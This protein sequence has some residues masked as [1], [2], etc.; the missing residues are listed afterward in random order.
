MHG[1]V[2]R[3]GSQIQFVPD[4][5]DQNFDNFFTDFTGKIANL[6]LSKK[7]TNE[8]Y[9]LCENLIEASM[10]LCG[11]FFEK[12]QKKNTEVVEI[13]NKS[14]NYVLDRIHSM[15]KS[16]M[17]E[18]QVLKSPF[19]VAPVEKAMGLQWKFKMSENSDLPNH[20]L[21]QTTFQFVPISQTI[22]SLFSHPEF[23]SKFFEY[24]NNRHE[25]VEGVFKDYCCGNLCKNNEIFQRK[26][27][28]LIQLSA[29]E[30]NTCCGLKTKANVH[31]VLGVYF[32][33][34]NMPIKHASKLNNIYL[35][36]LCPSI[37]FKEFGCSDDN[38]LEEVYRDL[39]MLEDNGVSIDENL[40]LNVALLSA[41]VDNLEAN[42]MLGFSEGFSAKFFCRFCE[43]TKEET[44]TLTVE[45]I[46]KR[47]SIE[48][49][50]LQL[51]NLESDPTLS[52][53]QTK[54]VHKNCVLNGL[55]NFHVLSNLTIDIMHDISEGV[56][57]YF[58]S[59]FYQ[60]CIDNRICNKPDLIHRIRDYNYGSLNKR[61]KPSQ[62]QIDRPNLG[63]NATQSYTIMMHLP[64]IFGDKR[65]QLHD[66]WPIMT[67]LLICMRIIYSFEISEREIEL[68]EKSASDHLAGMVNVF[69]ITLKPKHHHMLHH[70]NAIRQMGPPR[71]MWMMKYDSKHKFFTQQARKTNNFINITKSLAES[72]QPYICRQKF[73][74]DDEFE[75]SKKCSALSECNDY[76]IYRECLEQMQEI[77]TELV[78]AMHFLIV[79][80]KRFNKGLM[81]VHENNVHEIIFVLKSDSN[82]F[83]ICQ[84]YSVIKFEHLLNSFQIEKSNVNSENVLALNIRCLNMMDSFERKIFKNSFFL[85]AENTEVFNSLYTNQ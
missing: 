39:K 13:L 85:I 77:D 12:H 75:F 52:L 17:R 48:E 14:Q 5:I 61:N 72:H 1:T 11:N 23:K 63:Q 50:E 60:F 29:D 35:V 4:T 46:S 18:K 59:A 8:V 84:A 21:V 25:C 81:I 73:H 57:L 38:V 7:N 69:E 55:K 66:V 32:Q 20:Q 33:I 79:N 65:E 56:I 41:A 3:T 40:H 42:R 16:H 80:G 78:V 43:C 6:Q 51:E 26:D 19:Y 27:T 70:S 9:D 47:R 28:I 36:A 54:G 74:F 22:K 83:L 44:Q 58:L 15:N 76:I 53:Q 10:S 82:V 71:L 37:N 30:F 49:Y 31:K 2:V 64:F 62:L 45:N 24:N 67:S 34:R 68:Y